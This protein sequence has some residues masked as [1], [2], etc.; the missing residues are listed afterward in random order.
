MQGWADGVDFAKQTITVEEAIAH[1]THFNIQARDQDHDNHTGQIQ[2]ARES[3]QKA[4][5]R[6]DVPYDKLIISVGCYSKT[7]NI[8]GVREHSYFLKDISDARRIRRRILECFELASL[9]TTPDYIRDTLLR[10]A[11]VGGGPTGMEFAAEL[12]D[13][14]RYDLTKLYPR[15]L[16]D[17]VQI[18]VHDVAP[19][20]LSMF[21]QELGKYAMGVYSRQG[22]KVKPNHHVLGLRQGLPTDAPSGSADSADQKGCY[23][24]TTKQDGEMGVGMCVW[25]TGLM[26]NPFVEHILRET[27]TLPPSSIIPN[28]SQGIAITSGRSSHLHTAQGPNY[29]IEKSPKN[30]AILVDDNLRLQLRS[31]TPQPLQPTVTSP[32]SPQTVTDPTQAQQQTATLPNVYALGDTAQI[33][34]NSLPATAQ[35][36]SQQAIYLAKTLN[37]LPTV[38]PPS[39]STPALLSST[40]G[41]A[42]GGGA[43]RLM[44]SPDVFKKG[45]NNSTTTTTSREHSTT[46]NNNSKATLVS[47]LQSSRHY[48]TMPGFK[49]HNMGIMTYLGSARSIVQFERSKKNS[50]SPS[51]PSSSASPTSSSASSSSSSSSSIPSPTP[52][53]SPNAPGSSS[54]QLTPTTSASNTAMTP[55]RDLKGRTA[56]LV[57]RGAYLSMS[58]SWRNRVLMM[59]YWVVNWVGG[60]DVS[61]F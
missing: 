10:F 36:A 56:W 35:T 22:V 60:R 54:G 21:G 39:A 6:F 23:T 53:P 18:M 46:G 12:S 19:Q 29:Q 8:P 59:V 30:H 1:R 51:S 38:P 34:N 28:D 17:R 45:S 42:A 24:L 50:T 43:P 33:R 32:S 14:V 15:S 58:L 31:V 16:T 20:V 52:T 41:I 40:S 26:L 11:V 7:F 4:G 48:P 3:K 47:T 55:G 57:W 27:H 5:Q 13:L 44:P 9:P 2:M 37:K 49:F 61:R 25:S